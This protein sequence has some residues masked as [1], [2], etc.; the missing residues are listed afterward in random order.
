M[1]LVERDELEWEQEEF[2]QLALLVLQVLM[3]ESDAMR[4]V[5]TSDGMEEA[6]GV[7][8]YGSELESSTVVA[9][10]YFGP[11]TEPTELGSELVTE[12]ETV[13]SSDHLHKIDQIVPQVEVM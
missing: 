13:G 8:A 2:G 6:A 5:E 12:L 9:A 10:M 4:W 3:K 11:L 1:A 7:A